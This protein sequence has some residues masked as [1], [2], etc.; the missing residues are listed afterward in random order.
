ME[1]I[2]R[3]QGGS[4]GGRHGRD[5]LEGLSGKPLCNAVLDCLDRTLLVVWPDHFIAPGALAAD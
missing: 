4:A 5:R 2:A 3:E 1:E